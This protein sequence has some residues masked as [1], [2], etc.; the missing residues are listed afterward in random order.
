MCVYVLCVWKKR[1]LYREGPGPDGEFV[2]GLLCAAH[3]SVEKKKAKP[4][5]RKGKFHSVLSR[6]PGRTAPNG[7][8]CTRMKSRRLICP[9]DGR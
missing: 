3:L 7:G 5:K 8:V 4:A 2:G 1:Q 9:G 6:F